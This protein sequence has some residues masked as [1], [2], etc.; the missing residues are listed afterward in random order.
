MWHRAQAWLNIA[1]KQKA[2]SKANLGLKKRKIELQ[3]IFL[4]ES[5]SGSMKI[6]LSL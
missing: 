3:S 6:N 2:N 5:E 4:P 1:C